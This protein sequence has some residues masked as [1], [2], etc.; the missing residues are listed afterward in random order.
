MSY[1][2]LPNDIKYIVLPLCIT[3]IK[4]F[5]RYFQI[6]KNCYKKLDIKLWKLRLKQDYSV[7][8]DIPIILP[9]PEF[10]KNH[11]L[12]VYKWVFLHIKNYSSSYLEYM[13]K[14]QSIINKNIIDYPHIINMQNKLNIPKNFI[15]SYCFADR[16]STI[17]LKNNVNKLSFEISRRG[18][19]NEFDILD[20]NNQIIFEIIFDNKALLGFSYI[21]EQSME[22][23]LDI[24]LKLDLVNIIDLFI[25]SNLDNGKIW[26]IIVEKWKNAKKHDLWY[27]KQ[28]Y[29]DGEYIEYVIPKYIFQQM[30]IK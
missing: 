21:Y 11:Y 16:N 9:E 19:Y 28:E 24:L 26:D 23:L 17:Y 18:E 20:L 10:I 8:F 5:I 22:K 4:D 29:I 13:N 1:N 15:L 2:H 30:N 6:N 12:D 25:Q 7:C 27:N 14:L 3:K